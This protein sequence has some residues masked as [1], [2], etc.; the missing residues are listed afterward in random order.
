MKRE[1]RTI[2]TE[3]RVMPE[4]NGCKKKIGGYAARFNSM[5]Q[6][7]GGFT[8]RIAPGAFAKSLLTADVRCLFNHDA[9]IVLGRTLSKTLRLIEDEFGLMY[10]CDMPDTQMARDMVMA[11]IERGDVS[12]CSFGFYTIHDSWETI[13]GRQ[14][15]TLHECELLDVSPVTYPAYKSTDVSARSLAAAAVVPVNLWYIASQR[16]KLDLLEIV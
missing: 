16:R 8:E 2:S 12:E 13:E 15:R 9:N 6:D 11:P 5:S 10:E 1:V 4:A 14:V 7:L 3:L